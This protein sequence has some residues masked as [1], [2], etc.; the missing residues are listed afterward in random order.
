MGLPFKNEKMVYWR[1]V[2][3]SRFYRSCGDSCK[4]HSEAGFLA[5]WMLRVRKEIN[6]TCIHLI[7]RPSLADLQSR[8]PQNSTTIPP[9][10]LIQI[11]QIRPKSQRLNVPLIFL[12]TLSLCGVGNPVNNAMFRPEGIFFR[13][14]PLEKSTMASVCWRKQ[15]DERV[16]ME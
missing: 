13:L 2:S 12:R 1:F 4:R 3:C 14:M 15:L 5:S 10:S 8:N 7:F 6:G 9:V 16:L 11:D